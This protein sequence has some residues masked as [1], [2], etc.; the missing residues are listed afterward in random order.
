MLTVWQK[1]IVAAVFELC[2][3]GVMVMYEL[4]GHAKQ[5]NVAV[6]QRMAPAETALGRCVAG[7][8]DYAC[9]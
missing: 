5:L 1:A 6:A 4:L 2:C 3:V 9:C 8:S 7:L